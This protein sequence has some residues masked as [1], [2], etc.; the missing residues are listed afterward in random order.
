MQQFWNDYVTPIVTNK[1][2]VMNSHYI[3]GS[4]TSEAQGQMGQR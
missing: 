3:K 1:T 4:I 2:G